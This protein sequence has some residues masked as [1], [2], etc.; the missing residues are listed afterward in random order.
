[1]NNSNSYNALTLAFLGDAVYSLMVRERLV[2]SSSL[3]AGKLHKK[4][5]KSVNALAQSDA[6]KKLLPLLN[7]EET[8]IFKRA[9][10]AHPHHTPKNQSEGDYHYATGLEALFGWLYLEG[11][12]DR[13]N[14][15]FNLINE[16]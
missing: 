4:S 12:N 8:D 11:K 1:M 9:R 3:P 5:V 6:M 14:E 2:K 16:E 7:E 15:L 10:N 13:L